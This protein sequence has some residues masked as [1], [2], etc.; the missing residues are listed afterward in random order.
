MT[1]S[2]R[3]PGLIGDVFGAQAW[4]DVEAATVAE[5]VRVLDGRFPGMGERLTEP[6]GEMRRWVQ[7][8]VDGK[9]FRTLAGMGTR[10][11]PGAQVYIVPSVAGG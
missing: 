1:V 3:I 9:D 5:L 2:V 6:G 8:F 10:L 11:S 7:V 4:E